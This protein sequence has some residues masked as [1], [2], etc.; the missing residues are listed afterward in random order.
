MATL[1]RARPAIARVGGFPD[2]RWHFRDVMGDVMVVGLREIHVGACSTDFQVSSR[3]ASDLSPRHF[4]SVPR[5]WVA[6]LPRVLT[7]RDRVD[8]SGLRR[9]PEGLRV[10][11][12]GPRPSGARRG[13]QLWP[14][15][16]RE[17]GGSL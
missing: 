1:A 4:R 8:R 17:R 6:G 9:P 15:G 2:R 13:H 10:L 7:V 5:M 11:L 12:R 3:C 16:W 14:V